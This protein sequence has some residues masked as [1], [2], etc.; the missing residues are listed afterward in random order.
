MGKGFE[1]TCKK[2]HYSEYV[3]LGVGMSFPRVYEYLIDKA[4]DGS[5]GFRWQE[6]STRCNLTAIN[7]ERKFYLCPKCSNW[8]LDYDKSLYHPI[9]EEKTAAKLYRP[10]SIWQWN[11]FPYV[12][13][14]TLNSQY[15]KLA[16]YTHICKECG[17]AILCIQESELHHLHC[18]LQFKCP[19]CGTYNRIGSIGF[20]D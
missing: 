16:H 18:K 9:D 13:P 20:W 19:S 1:Y 15:H 10:D 11:D 6:L 7:A 8:K 2:C 14:R 3:N 5:L 12:S 17:T 4:H